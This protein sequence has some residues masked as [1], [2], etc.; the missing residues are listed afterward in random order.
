[1][2]DI[3]NN[4][5]Y[6]RLHA[7]RDFGNGAPV[8]KALVNSSSNAAWPLGET[9][10]ST[11]RKIPVQYAVVEADQLLPSN[12]ALGNS[13]PEYANGVEGK[14][15]AI[16]GNGRVAGITAAWK[17]SKPD[18]AEAYKKQMIEDTQHGIDPKVIRA[19]KQPVLVRIMPLEEV[20]N[21]IGDESNVSGQA[22]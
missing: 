6:D 3:K 16:A 8:V 21:N 5:D 14:S 20:S 18:K 19:M 22:G 15:R 17:S 1:M 7:S 13:I 11:G 12:D 10:T 2:Q 4:P 9:T